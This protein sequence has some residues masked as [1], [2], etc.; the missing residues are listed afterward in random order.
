MPK[1]IDDDTYRFCQWL[2]DFH[3]YAAHAGDRR[4]VPTRRLRALHRAG[5]SVARAYVHLR[6]I[7]PQ[8]AQDQRA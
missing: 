7:A 4:K 3:R 5:L 8:L 1:L 6:F 2:I